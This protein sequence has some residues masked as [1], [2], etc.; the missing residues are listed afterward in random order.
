MATPKLKSPGSV[1]TRG[2]ILWIKF[3]GRRISTGYIDTPAGRKQAEMLKDQMFL[4]WL[5]NNG[6]LKIDNKLT[7]A[8]AGQIILKRNKMNG[9]IKKL[10]KDYFVSQELIN[11][12]YFDNIVKHIL[13]NKKITERTKYNKLVA[14]NS[15][16]KYLLENEYIDGIK[17]IKIF[18]KPDSEYKVYSWEEYLKI[19]RYLFNYNKENKFYIRRY[20]LGCMII[21]YRETGLRRTELFNLKENQIDYQRR[22]ILLKNKVNHNENEIALM[23]KKSIYFIKQYM[24]HSRLRPTT[25][26]ALNYSLIRAERA[27]GIKHIP[28]RGF[29]SFRKLFSDTLFENNL[30]LDV[31]RNAMRHK[32]ISTTIAIYKKQYRSNEIGLIDNIKKMKY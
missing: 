29:H 32:S 8:N 23:P 2:N 22:I 11:Q 3:K 25:T 12:T 24:K 16:I 9:A 4:E 7:A 13:A 5:T 21:I 17:K 28:G 10:V 30:P 26:V 20:L 19:L 6:K 27:V 1:Y 14:L 31:I 18:K 15:I